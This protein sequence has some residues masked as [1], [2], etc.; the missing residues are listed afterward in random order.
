MPT[1]ELPACNPIPPSWAVAILP[2]ECLPLASPQISYLVGREVTV[3]TLLLRQDE[4]LA[5]GRSI[6]YNVSLCTA[7]QDMHLHVR[8]HS[9]SEYPTLE[10]ACTEWLPGSTWWVVFEGRMLD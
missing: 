7:F 5:A 2:A 6:L 9:L 4:V 1:P 8:W 10:V 3:L